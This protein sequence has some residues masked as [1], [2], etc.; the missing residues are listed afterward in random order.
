MSLMRVGP[1][2]WVDMNCGG[3]PLLAAP[4]FCHRLTPA[5]GL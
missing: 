5:R 4:I 3:A 1:L 2:G